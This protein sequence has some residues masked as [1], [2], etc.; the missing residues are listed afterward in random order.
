MVFY[1]TADLEY[2]AF[3]VSLV[4]SVI[5]LSVSDVLSIVL[6]IN[7]YYA[8]VRIRKISFTQ[9]NQCNKVKGRSQQ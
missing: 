2:C 4:D 5:I 3:A 8:H 1:S 6:K 7:N 9:R